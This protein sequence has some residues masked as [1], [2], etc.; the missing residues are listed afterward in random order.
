MKRNKQTGDAEIWMMV[1]V[2]IALLTISWIVNVVG[3]TN[4]W[5]ETGYKSKY[6][7]TSGCMV[8]RTNGTWVPEKMLRDVNP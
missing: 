7:I 5:E 6:G 8:Q 2:L 4:R 3:C 1:V